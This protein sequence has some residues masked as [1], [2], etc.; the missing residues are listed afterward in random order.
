MSSGQVAVVPLALVLVAPAVVAAAAIGAAG[1]AVANAAQQA[2]L[3]HQRSRVVVA[4]S[5]RQRLVE[6]AQVLRVAPP[7]GVQ[8]SGST[9]ISALRALANKLAKENAAW[10]ETLDAEQSKLNALQAKVDSAWGRHQVVSRWAHE[11]ALTHDALASLPTLHDESAVAE[12]EHQLATVQAHVNTMERALRARRQELENNA[13]RHALATITM[14]P[15]AEVDRDPDSSSERWR[16][17]LRADLSRAVREAQ[18]DGGLPS[19]VSVAFQSLEH[20]TNPATAQT[21]INDAVAE[22]E[23]RASLR[24]TTDLFLERVAHWAA[25]ADKVGSQLLIALCDE[26]LEQFEER[27]AALD[28][29]E[30]NAWVRRQ[31]HDLGREAQALL[32]EHARS[33]HV[34]QKAAAHI[35]GAFVRDRFVEALRA[36]NYVEVPMETGIPVDGHLFVRPSDGASDGARFGK[37]VSLDEDGELVTYPVRLGSAAGNSLDDAECS[38]QVS[39]ERDLLLPRVTKALAAVADGSDLPSTLFAVEHNQ[40]IAVP[41]FQMSET[42]RAALEQI[43]RGHGFGVVKRGKMTM[44]DPRE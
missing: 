35:V 1:Y 37:V 9:D 2:A 6:Q 42:L 43:D 22:L 25:E 20:A 28:H 14:P 19:R 12:A 36:Q 5:R 24:S 11:E 8:S 39:E 31:L 15:V 3:A 34:E 44:G 26:A 7:P 4:S 18:L 33:R 23:E 16:R 40:S 41:N 29:V 30:L 10:E 38:R 21:L 27:R 17:A 32:D 13:Q